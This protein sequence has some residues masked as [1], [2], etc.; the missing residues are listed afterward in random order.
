MSNVQTVFLLLISFC[1]YSECQVSYRLFCVL[2]KWVDN[3]FRSFIFIFIFILSSRFSL[4]VWTVLCL[5]QGLL[6]GWNNSRN[7]I[8]Y[9]FLQSTSTQNKSNLIL[10]SPYHST[11]QSSYYH[12]NP[13]YNCGRHLHILAI[14]QSHDKLVLN[15]FKFLTLTFFS[16]WRTR[17]TLPRHTSR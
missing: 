16:I 4:D 12:T 9:T 14:F 1:D 5:F 10:K 3:K 2:T 6:F 7:Y 8:S 15:Q 13:T 17:P 11:L